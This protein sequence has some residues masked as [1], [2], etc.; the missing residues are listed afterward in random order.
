MHEDKQSSGLPREGCL[1]HAV[2][3]RR[4]NGPKVERDYGQVRYLP[5]A[6]VITINFNEHFT[7]RLQ[8][9]FEPVQRKFCSKDF[10]RLLS[11]YLT[12]KTSAKPRHPDIRFSEK[13]RDQP[14]CP[15]A[16]ILYLSS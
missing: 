2:R 14:F 13:Q 1:K 15:N 4:K 5:C 10:L 3:R 12:R 11:P 7:S 9:K 8:C 16:H 6:Y